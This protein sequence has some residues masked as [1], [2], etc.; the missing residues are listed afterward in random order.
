MK[1]LTLLVHP[2]W[3]CI[4]HT[5]YWRVDISL[6]LP[7]KAITA[8]WRTCLNLLPVS[9]DG[10]SLTIAEIIFRMPGALITSSF[11]SLFQENSIISLHEEPWRHDPD[12]RLQIWLASFDIILDAPLMTASLWSVIKAFM[13]VS[14]FSVST[15]ALQ[16]VRK[17]SFFMNFVLFPLG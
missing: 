15:I 6:L 5:M 2:P 13:M 10:I 11:L 12:F 14:A 1:I 7:W 9:D 8:L 4:M 16:T 3:A 17:F